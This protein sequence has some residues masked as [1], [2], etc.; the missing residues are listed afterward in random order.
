MSPCEKKK[1]GNQIIH[2]IKTLRKAREPVKSVCSIIKFFSCFKIKSFRL[3]P[4]FKF[5]YRNI[6]DLF[7]EQT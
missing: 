4:K 2:G 1:T 3:I 5:N 7:K 6:Y